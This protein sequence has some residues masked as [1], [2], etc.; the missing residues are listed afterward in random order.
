MALIPP[1]KNGNGIRKIHGQGATPSSAFPGRIAST[2]GYVNP[3]PYGFNQATPSSLD[4]TPILLPSPWISLNG[5][6][7]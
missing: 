4:S 6:N 7:P 5:A 3:D 1:A 2:L